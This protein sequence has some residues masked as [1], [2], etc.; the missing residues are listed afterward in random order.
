VTP[1][2]VS[3]AINCGGHPNDLSRELVEGEI[4][5]RVSSTAA[6]INHVALT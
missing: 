5:P 2:G 4:G 6:E 1:D 3:L